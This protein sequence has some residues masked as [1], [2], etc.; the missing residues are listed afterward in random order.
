MDFDCYLKKKFFLV[1]INWT[2]QISK[3]SF[4]SLSVYNASPWV[5]YL[6][7][8]SLHAHLRYFVSSNLNENFLMQ[9]LIRENHDL[10]HFLVVI[11]VRC[12]IQQEIAGTFKNTTHA[13]CLVSLTLVL[14]IY[15]PWKVSEF[16]VE[17]KSLLLHLHHWCENTSPQGPITIFIRY[18]YIKFYGPHLYLCEV[19]VINFF[20]AC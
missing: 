10:C 17:Q 11:R 13:L 5:Q 19:E 8:T 15:R 20:T 18:F 14:K 6:S 4:S 2:A 1:T 12:R 3:H 16:E 9:N 7:R